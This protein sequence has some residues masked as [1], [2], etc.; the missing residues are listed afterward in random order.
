MI[1]NCDDV[2][3]TLP[4]LLN[5]TLG[6]EERQRVL[7]HLTGCASC[8]QD[9]ADTRLAAEIF[10]QHPPAEAILALAW[11]ETPS[12][13]DPGLLEEHLAA[14]PRCAAELELARMS[15]RLEQDEQ[16]VP[17]VRRT[18]PPAPA[19]G[20]GWR[21][22]RASAL[23]AGLAGVVAFAGWLHTAGRVDTL[24]ETLATRPGPQAPAPPMASG[25]A[26]SQQ[27]AAEIE[28]RGRRIEQLEAKL[29]AAQQQT[30]EL[31]GKVEQLAQV[32]PAAPASAAPQINVWARDLSPSAD[33]V[34]GGAAGPME[35][36]GQT[37]A[38]L[39][40]NADHPETHREHVVEI[41]DSTGKVVWNANGLA[42]D[43]ATDAYGLTLPP[44]SLRPGGYT[45][46]VYGLADGRREPAES[47]P[48]R[49][50]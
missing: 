5:G 20:T 31:N 38:T 47:Y 17:L 49:V 19:A 12:G 37:Y 39:L 2:R 6:D 28:E 35:I 10:D 33:V 25:S 13:L 3:G 15:R 41:E 7:R 21:G 50:Q 11:D 30:E 16:I 48:I 42:R 36:P 22:W 4:W 18:A 14:C 34:R 1:S 26:T 32:R 8:R 23:A 40:L 45:I 29:N 24:E 27:L 46:R 43:P 44:G 9:L